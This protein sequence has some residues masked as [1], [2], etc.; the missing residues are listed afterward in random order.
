MAPEASAPDKQIP[1]AVSLRIFKGGR[2]PYDFS[3]LMELRKVVDFVC[4]P[5]DK[6]GSDNFQALYMSE[7]KPEAKLFIFQS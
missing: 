7:L 2:L 3:I 5:P 1:E 4:S 6:Y